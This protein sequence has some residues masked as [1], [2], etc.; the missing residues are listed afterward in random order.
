MRKFKCIFIDIYKVNVWFILC[1]VDYYKRIMKTKLNY[2]VKVSDYTA[3]QHTHI[4]Y[5]D[6]KQFVI[7][8]KQWDSL[9]HELLHCVHSI[10]DYKGLWLTD[11]SE[12]AY[13]YLIEYLEK[14]FR[15]NE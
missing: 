6:N 10:L 3:G 5:G 8:I 4:E 2:T 1:P 9:T 15:K 12:E 14:E 11:S 13:A 7:W